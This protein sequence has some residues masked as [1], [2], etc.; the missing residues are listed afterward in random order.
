MIKVGIICPCP[1][2]Y[3][4][5]R[6]I[7]ELSNETE[8]AGRAVAS[9]TSKD[10][11]LMAI[12][13]GPGKTQ[14]ASAA[15][16]VIDN[17][18]PD[19]IID[20]GGAG[21]L[22]NEL[23]I[24]DIVCVK[25]AF[26]YDVCDVDKFS[27]WARVLTTSTALKKLLSFESGIMEEFTDWVALHSSARLVIGNIASGEKIIAGGE[28]RQDLREKLGAIA[29][30]WET[31]AVLKTAQLNSVPAFSFRVITDMAGKNFKKEL[32]KNWKSTLKVLYAV[33]KEF[34]FHGWLDRIS[35]AL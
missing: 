21:A 5:C 16:L 34:I 6:N 32:K 31:S 35:Q 11:D 20:V 26:E 28:L 14:C 4:T 23:K 1:V 7:L 17:F 13:A 9:K 30:D 15:Q 19:Y 24:N 25:D 2:E 8:S 33:L 22:S 3:K 10:I 27:K 29:C 12:E 18:H